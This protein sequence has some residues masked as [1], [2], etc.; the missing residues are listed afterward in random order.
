MIK[1]TAIKCFLAIPFSYFFFKEEW[2]S[3]IMCLFLL[4]IIDTIL[5]VMLA[6]KY[7][8]FTSYALGRKGSMKLIRYGLAIGTIYLLAVADEKIFGWAVHYI[9]MFF[10]LTEVISNF[11]KLSL[12]GLELPTKFMSFINSKYKDL[13]HDNKKDRDGS[14]KEM[15]DES[16]KK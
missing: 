2:W 7:K 15:V 13:L 1:A 5:G 12:L 14:V 9:T 8:K 4:T 16:T 10:I 11:E 6:I 3:V